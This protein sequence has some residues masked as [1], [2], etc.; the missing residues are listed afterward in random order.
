[1]FEDR[2]SITLSGGKRKMEVRPYFENSYT[3]KEARRRLFCAPTSVATF[4]TP[5]CAGRGGAPDSFIQCL[6]TVFDLVF[7]I[8]Y[9]KDSF[10]KEIPP[11]T[12]IFSHL[13]H[14]WQVCI[15]SGAPTRERGLV[16]R[17]YA[18]GV[19]GGMNRKNG[20]ASISDE[21]RGS[22]T[23]LLFVELERG[24]GKER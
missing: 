11:N 1:M 20:T 10:R 4:L 15:R 7:I 14:V 18:R 12:L 8:V 24:R 2:S 3:K 23:T 16:S 21:R 6:H 13:F 5:G 22:R 9:E 19:G 17:D